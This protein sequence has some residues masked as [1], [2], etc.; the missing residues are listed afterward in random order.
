MKSKAIFAHMVP[1]EGVDADGYAVVRLMEDVKW[2]GYTKILLK[3]DNEKAI[4][5]LLHDSL[6]RIKTE[7]LDLE[8]IGKEH[9]P[10][11]DS[12]SNGSVENA[13]KAVQGLLRT[14]KLGFEEKI[15]GTVPVTHPV[16][17]WMAEHAAWILST[18]NVGA[19]GRTPYHTVRG[20]PFTRRLVE[21]GERCLYKLPTKGPRHDERGK[22]EER[23]RRGVFLGFARQSNEYVF[24]DEDKVVKSRSHQRLRAELRW[25]QSVHEGVAADPHIT[26]AALLP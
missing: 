20:R 3:A 15:K 21:F 26:Y 5:K 6:R 24:W 1:R 14:L 2:L 25:P 22:L 7:V 10:A 17:A 19:N 8:Q 18:R 16:M 23:W 4:V 13:V 12:R 9:P 11:Y